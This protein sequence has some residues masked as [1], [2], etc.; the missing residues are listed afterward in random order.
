MPLQDP[1]QEPLQAPPQPPQEQPALPQVPSQP[2]EGLPTQAQPQ[3]L[4]EATEAPPME[5]ERRIRRRKKHNL[6]PE[7]VTTEPF[8]ADDPL[9]A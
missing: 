8:A 9:A 4:S 2:Q 1:K 6:K 7:G 5:G 3:D